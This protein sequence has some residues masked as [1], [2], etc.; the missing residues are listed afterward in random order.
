MRISA[1]CTLLLCLALSACGK[2]SSQHVNAVDPCAD[3]KGPP[4]YQTDAQAV[5]ACR[6]NK[7]FSGP[8]VKRSKVQITNH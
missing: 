7:R 5:Q 4:P 2:S 3:S 8:D 1:F 6:D